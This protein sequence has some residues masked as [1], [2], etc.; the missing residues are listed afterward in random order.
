MDIKKLTKENANKI[1]DLLIN[2]GGASSYER[3]DFV[4]HHVESDSGCD[5]WRFRGNLGFGGKYRSHTNRVDCYREDA[6]PER[7][8]I[9]DNLNSELSKL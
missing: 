5:E 1:Y 2:I 7:I 9:T 3:S 4:Y 8:R 6:T